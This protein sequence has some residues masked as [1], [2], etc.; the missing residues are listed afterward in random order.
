L[1]SHGPCKRAYLAIP[2]INLRPDTLD[3]SAVIITFGI[4]GKI[5]SDPK[6]I[7][8]LQLVPSWEAIA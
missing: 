2:R 1:K 6:T 7:F 5:I 3:V 8:M 4:E